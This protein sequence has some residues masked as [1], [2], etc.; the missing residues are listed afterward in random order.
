MCAGGRCQLFVNCTPLGGPTTGSRPQQAMVPSVRTPHRWVPLAPI[1]GHRAVGTQATRVVPAGIDRT[2][3]AAG[4]GGLAVIVVTPTGNGLVGAK[5][6]RVRNTGIN[7]GVP[8][9]R[10]R[11]GRARLG[12]DHR[13]GRARQPA[14][15]GGGRGE[16]AR[17]RQQIATQGAVAEN[18]AQ[19]E[20]NPTVGELAR[21]DAHDHVLRRAARRP[22]D[23]T[24]HRSR[25]VTRRENPQTSPICAPIIYAPSNPHQC[26][27]VVG[28]SR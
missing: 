21:H 6:T 22:A 19:P 28:N 2:E 1:T 16:H 5:P 14:A 25:A 7:T 27:Q 15:D 8:G 10:G 17:S 24:R 13:D 3:L 18:L 4:C 23:R 11:G 9:S 20:L 26:S 12:G